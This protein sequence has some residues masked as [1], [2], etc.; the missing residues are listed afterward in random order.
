MHA[1]M[2]EDEETIKVFESGAGSMDAEAYGNA[3]TRLAAN[4]LWNVWSD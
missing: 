4:I 1:Q 3:K 2:T